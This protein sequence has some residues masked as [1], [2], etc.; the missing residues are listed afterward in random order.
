MTVIPVFA[1]PGFF[2]FV[3]DTHKRDFI[4]FGEIAGDT[5]AVHRVHRPGE[6]GFGCDARNVV[7]YQADAA[8]IDDKDPLR[9][10][11]CLYKIQP[12]QQVF[13]RSVDQGVAFRLGAVKAAQGRGVEVLHVFHGVKVT[14][15]GPVD[16]HEAAG[17][18]GEESGSAGEGAG[19][20]MV[21]GS[22]PVLFMHKQSLPYSRNGI[23]AG[24]CCASPG[25]PL[26]CRPGAPWE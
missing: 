12:R 23:R 3:Y 9:G 18:G 1:F 15:E 10:K 25:F 8:V 2:Y 4:S 21:A 20:H 17:Y 14:P 16:Q 5:A 13:F 19:R 6:T 22:G 24:K 26:R 7:A 11:V